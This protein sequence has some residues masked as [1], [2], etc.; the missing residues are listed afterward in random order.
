MYFEFVAAEFAEQEGTMFDITEEGF[1]F[2]AE[3]VRHS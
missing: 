2:V 3:N 1:T